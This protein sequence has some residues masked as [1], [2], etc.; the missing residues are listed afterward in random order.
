[1]SASCARTGAGAVMCWGTGSMVGGVDT[2]TPT[3]IPTLASGVI[4]IAGHASFACAIKADHSLVCWGANDYGQLGIN[5]TAG[6][7]TPQA[8]TTGVAQI[9]AGGAHACAIKDD[10]TVWC[11]GRNDEGQLGTGDQRAAH[12][13]TQITLDGPALAI[14][15]GDAQTCVLT[16]SG[17]SCWGSDIFGELG[18]GI[19][20][21]L[22][23]RGVNLP[24]D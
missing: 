11:W 22:I 12:L 1:N 9:A 19:V 18:D 16:G 7:Q 6:H 24:C 8:V 15:A 13:P 2:D 3:T 20:D 14:V 4:A 10:G 23:P 17:M 21:W 5:T